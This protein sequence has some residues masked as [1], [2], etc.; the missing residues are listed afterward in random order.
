[1]GDL[2]VDQDRFEIN[3]V[4]LLQ[5]FAHPEHS[6]WF[7]FVSIIIFEVDIVAEQKQ[8]HFGSDF[9]FFMFPLPST[10]FMPPALPMFRRPC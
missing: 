2:I 10:L 7:C 5:L 9:L 4:N 6:K 1:M 3:L 8:A